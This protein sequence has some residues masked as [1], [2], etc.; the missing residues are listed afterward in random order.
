MT[1]EPKDGGQKCHAK[2]ERRNSCTM[3]G[4]DVVSRDGPSSD[5]LEVSSLSHTGQ[6]NAYAQTVPA[7]K[8]QNLG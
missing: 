2:N 5:S 3:D 1:E 6:S 4:D 7:L 8:R